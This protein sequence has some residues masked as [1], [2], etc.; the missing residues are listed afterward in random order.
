MRII[1][2]GVNGRLGSAVAE[3]AAG[4]HQVAAG[5]DKVFDKQNPF[6]VYGSL[7][8]VREDADVIIDCSVHGAVRELLSHAGGKPVVIAATGHDREE[9]DFIRDMAGRLPL[10]MAANLSL[11]I[12]ILMEMSARIAGLIGGSFDIEIV[13]AHHNKK[14][15]APSGTALA[16]AGGINKAL[17]APRDFVYDRT[18]RR[19]ARSAGE[20]GIHSV[21]GGTIVGEHEVIFAGADETLRLSHSAQSRNIYA[22]GALAAAAFLLKQPNGLYDMRSLLSDSL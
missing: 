16:I 1:I 2:S 14:L 7:A 12:N 11:G 4:K 6:P 8:E 20:I 5:V 18:S 13:E 9:M 10:F 3:G 22:E 17:E 19:A 15:D 21:R